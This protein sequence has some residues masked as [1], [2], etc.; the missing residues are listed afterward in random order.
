MNNSFPSADSPV[1][2]YNRRV[3][4]CNVHILLPLLPFYYV[5]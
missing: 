2:S 4:L 3:S 1:V 5:S